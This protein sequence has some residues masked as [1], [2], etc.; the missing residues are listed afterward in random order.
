MSSWP[1]FRIT[2]T[3]RGRDAHGKPFKPGALRPLIFEEDDFGGATRFK[4]FNPNREAQLRTL[5]EGTPFTPEDETQKRLKENY[6]TISS[7]FDEFFKLEADPTGLDLAKLT[8][9]ITYLL[10][11]VSIV[12]I[13]IIWRKKSLMKECWAMRSIL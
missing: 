10:D 2:T 9:Y 12:E 3:N 5:V 4:I 8:Y 11:R 1:V 6:A 13:R 7:Y